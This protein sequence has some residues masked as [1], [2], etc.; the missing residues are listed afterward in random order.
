M[1]KSMNK[2]LKLFKVCTDEALKEPPYEKTSKM[3][4][5]PSEDSDQPG[6]QPSLIS[7]RCPHEENLGTELP[8]KRTAKTL[9]RLGGSESSLGTHAVLL[10]LS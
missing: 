5:V 6:H 7:H 9:I 2:S 10:V 3:A 8:I 4:C 1:N